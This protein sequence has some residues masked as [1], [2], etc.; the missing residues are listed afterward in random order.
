MPRSG[1]SRSSRSIQPACSFSASPRGIHPISMD[2]KVFHENGAITA[3]NTCAAKNSSM[4]AAAMS[5]TQNMTFMRPSG[6][7]ST[8][9][10][11]ALTRP[12]TTSNAAVTT[13]IT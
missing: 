4:S 3:K 12:V 9:W 7:V 11:N 8:T 5:C 6:S 10:A 2:G 13:A 1:C